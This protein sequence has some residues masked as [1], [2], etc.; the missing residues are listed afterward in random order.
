MFS[1]DD[2]NSKLDDLESLQKDIFR[3]VTK[4]A[5]L[6]EEAMIFAEE[7][8]NEICS[9]KQSLKSL[10][11]NLMSLVNDISDDLIIREEQMTHL[12]V[13]IV[14]IMIITQN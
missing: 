5:S 3:E 7:F 6:L 13:C 1:G 9:A 11:E 8:E 14:V 10:E 12:K 4:R 2:L